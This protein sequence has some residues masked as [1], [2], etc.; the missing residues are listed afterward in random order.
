LQDIH[1]RVSD[2]F[3]RV[4]GKEEETKPKKVWENIFLFRCGEKCLKIDAEKKKNLLRK[5]KTK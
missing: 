5:N 4:A 1:P 2:L 3:V